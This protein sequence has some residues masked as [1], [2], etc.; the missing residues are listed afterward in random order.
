[1]LTEIRETTDDQWYQAWRKRELSRLD[2]HGITYLD[3]TGTPPYPASTVRSDARRL[4]T[5]ILGNPHSESSASLAST[6]DLDSARA[7]ILRFVNADPAAYGVVL[8]ANASGACR[9]VGEAWPFG[10]RRPLVL[11]QDNHN[12]VNGLREF[13][14]ARGAP[15]AVVPLDGNL[16]LA[17]AERVLVERAHSIGGLFAFPAQSNFSG[18]RHPLDLV[19]LARSLGYRTLLDAAGFVPTTALDLSRVPADFVT[20]SIYK[21][22]GY[23]TG[24]GALVARHDALAELS[25]PWFAGGTVDWVS[26]AGG[27]HR[28]RQGVERF[29]DGTPPFLAAGAV[30]PALDAIM[31]ADR[32]RLAEHLRALTGHL[33]RGLASLRHAN[34]APLVAIHGPTDLH[35]RGATVAIT[36]RDPH[37]TVFPFWSVEADARDAG[38]AIRGGCFCNPGCAE[39][40]FGWSATT[41]APCLDALGAQFTIPKFAECLG[42]G[43]AGAIR[44]SLGLGSLRR[45]V[46]VALTFFGGYRS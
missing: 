31:A 37:G 10:P 2:H 35:S 1:M 8:C 23:P 11:S 45:D 4:D 17:G 42:Q 30:A 18:V 26:V 38:L 41:T 22:T 25:R 20:L 36:L 32:P 12:S 19:P 34:G 5:A 3:Y 28:L 21:I 33:L 40:A 16:R 13:A 6:R 29:E 9:L 7:A 15:V 39:A 43:P 27:R 14:R 24:I 46:D 44:M